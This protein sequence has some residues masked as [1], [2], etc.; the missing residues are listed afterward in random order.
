[1]KYFTWDFMYADEQKNEIQQN[2][3]FEEFRLMQKKNE[4]N[5]ENVKKVFSRE[6]L[7][8]YEK[9]GAFHDYEITNLDIH[10]NG[11]SNIY[12]R[13][14]IIMTLSGEGEYSIHYKGVS[15]FVVVNEIDS[16]YSRAVSRWYKVDKYL[17]DEFDV[18]ENGFYTHDVLLATGSTLRI[19]FRKI[20]IKEMK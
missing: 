1:M 6:S 18:S 19:K 17:Y 15:N 2:E 16:D 8:N 14:E 3:H 5:F 4:K 9:S 20:I 12:P 13:L 7:H 11:K 10:N